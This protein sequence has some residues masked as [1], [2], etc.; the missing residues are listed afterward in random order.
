MFPPP[1]QPKWSSLGGQDRGAHLN[2]STFNC[3]PC[4]NDLA[5][6]TRVLVLSWLKTVGEIV[7]LGQHSYH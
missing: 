2:S 5:D 7:H 4:W 1:S 6:G 3:L